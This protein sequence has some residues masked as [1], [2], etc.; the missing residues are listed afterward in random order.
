[1]AELNRDATTA[2]ERRE[3]VFQSVGRGG[4][5]RGKL[6]QHRAEPRSQPLRPRNEQIDRFTG[7]AKTT[8][9]GEVAARLHGHQEARGRL[10]LPT[11][12]RR[13]FWEPVEGVVDLNRREDGRIVAEPPRR[14]EA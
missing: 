5:I 9:V 12:E 6:E 1:M 11:V 13:G 2:A 8:D 14:G 7:I 3:R 4:E 10:P